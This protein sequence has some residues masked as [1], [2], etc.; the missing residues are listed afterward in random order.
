M[1]KELMMFGYSQ[2]EVGKQNKLLL[3]ALYSHKKMS[4]L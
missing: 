2:S 1:N 4:I 3:K